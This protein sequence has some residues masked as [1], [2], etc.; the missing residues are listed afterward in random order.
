M[1]TPN[2]KMAGNSGYVLLRRVAKPV[3]QYSLNTSTQYPWAFP[4]ISG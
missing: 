4:A 3:L 1:S 2:H